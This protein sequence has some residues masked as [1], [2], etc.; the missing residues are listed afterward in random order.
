MSEREGNSA[1]VASV[2]DDRTGSG[3]FPDPPDSDFRTGQI[4]E[5]GVSVVSK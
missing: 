2:P 1:V 3:V 5:A 4:K